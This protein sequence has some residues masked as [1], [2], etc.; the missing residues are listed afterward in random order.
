MNNYYI[1]YYSVQ[2]TIVSDYKYK[3]I[4]PAVGAN[5]HI[6][7]IYLAIMIDDI[8]CAEIF[9]KYIGKFLSKEDFISKIFKYINN[10]NQTVTSMFDAI[11]NPIQN[12]LI[13]LLPKADKYTCKFNE[14]NYLRN[15]FNNIIY[16][17]F[18]SCDSM[19]NLPNDIIKVIIGYT[20]PEINF[21]IVCEVIKTEHKTTHDPYPSFDNINTSHIINSKK[22]TITL[23]I[24]TYN[25]PIK[26]Q[27]NTLYQS[28]NSEIP[29][30]HKNDTEHIKYLI[31]R[32]S[33]PTT[34][35]QIKYLEFRENKT[36]TINL[37]TLDKLSIKYD[38]G[39]NLYIFKYDLR[40]F[41]TGYVDFNLT[42]IFKENTTCDIQLIQ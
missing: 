38:I 28:I 27:I 10:N 2:P 22:I 30:Y 29:I 16:N 33:K 17:Y 31:I 21:N 5:E 18:R 13:I 34:K 14:L 11:H 20:E 3:Y 23:P 42:I 26:Y 40:N 37:S 1:K 15:M 6:D 9:N 36:H 24:E 39:D 41:C 8:Y 12:Y 7:K 4:I 19:R 25:N 35:Y 32:I